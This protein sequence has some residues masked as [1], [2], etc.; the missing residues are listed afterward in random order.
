MWYIG[1][2]VVANIIIILANGLFSQMP[3]WQ[4][5][6]FPPVATLTVILVDGI[7][8]FL[9]RRLPEKY[10]EASKTKAP[11]ER[12]RKLYRKLGIKRWKNK[13]PELGG[14][15]SFHKD[16]LESAI[17]KSYL[18]KFL[19]E[20]NYGIV[21]H[22]VNVMTGFLIIFIPFCGPLTVTLPVAAVNA[23]LSALPIFILRYNNAALYRA[24]KRAK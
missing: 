23:F 15:T 18:A 22:A 3:L 21:C 13:V 12:E 4:S 6:V 20:A 16:H 19:L 7:G 14:F 1:I 5:L 9:S 10:F 17:D 11:S 2:I 8:A 24:Y